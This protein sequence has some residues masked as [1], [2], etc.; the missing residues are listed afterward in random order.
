[1]FRVVVDSIE[2]DRVQVKNRAVI[3][4]IDLAGSEGIDRTKAEGIVK[5]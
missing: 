4:L 3:N 5:K 2:K 1:V